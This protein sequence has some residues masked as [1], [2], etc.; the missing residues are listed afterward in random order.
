MCFHQIIVEAGM[1]LQKMGTEASSLD[2][3]KVAGAGNTKY[4]KLTDSSDSADDEE[5]ELFSQLRKPTLPD[6][7]V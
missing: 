2:H 7:L 5:D 1:K 3:K 6:D 4:A